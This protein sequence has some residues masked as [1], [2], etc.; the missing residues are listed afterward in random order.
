MI[1]RIQGRGQANAVRSRRRDPT[2][3]LSGDNLSYR[4][5]HE[6]MTTG[7][8]LVCHH[9]NRVDV[10]PRN[11]D[12]FHST[13]PER[14][15]RVCRTTSPAFPQLPSQHPT[16]LI[17]PSLPRSTLPGFRSPWISAC[18][19]RWAKPRRT[20]ISTLA[21]ADRLM[22]DAHAG[23]PQSEPRHEFHG[24]EDLTLIG[25]APV[26]HLHEVFM[27]DLPQRFE[28]T[29]QPLREMRVRPPSGQSLIPAVDPG[30]GTRGL[31]HLGLLLPRACT[32][33]ARSGIRANYSLRMT[34]SIPP[35]TVSS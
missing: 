3:E 5:P 27:V 19:W 18:E 26:K 29:P 2:C 9:A 14:H 6:G 30:H 23:A 7:Q 28:L 4:L 12:V 21:T 17:D 1:S 15:T 13:V 34:G 35:T 11:Q 20:P 22:C 24:V 16:I 31:H 10:G 25:D 8:S 33:T 32:V